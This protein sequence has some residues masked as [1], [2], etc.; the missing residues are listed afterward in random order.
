MYTT[1]SNAAALE[2]IIGFWEKS[3]LEDT[4]VILYGLMYPGLFLSVG[5]ARRYHLPQANL[6]SYNMTFGNRIFARVCRRRSIQSDL[7]WS[8]AMTMYLWMKR[9]ICCRLYGQERLSKLF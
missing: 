3:G 7:W 9:Q 5:C 8:L 6:E 1:Q 4:P 2:E